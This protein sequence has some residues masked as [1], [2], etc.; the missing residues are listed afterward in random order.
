M[1]ILVGL[2]GQAVGV[3]SFPFMAR[4]AVE[5]RIREMS[6]L[7]NSTLRYIALVIP[8]SALLIVLRQEVIV[9][10]FQRGR[11]DAAATALTAQVLIFFLA[12]AFAFAA[13]TVVVRGYYAMQNTLF[14]AVFG[15]TAVVLSIPFYIG[16]MHLFGVSGVAL[17]VSLSAIFQVVL[18][19]AL[20]NRRCRNPASRGVYSVYARVT[21]LSVVLGAVLELLK[22][23]LLEDVAV[24]ALFGNL[25]V[26]ALIGIVF[27]AMLLAGGT[28]LRIREISTII[29]RATGREKKKTD[30][31]HRRSQR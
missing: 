27:S 18:L 3:A 14:P 17:A 23:R 20:W 7:L 13:Q 4:L 24:S 19:Y 31:E 28:M 6:D 22:T 2:F 12:G 29:A 1:L 15:S 11:F 21:G 5:N 10:L 8:F 25:M 16:G 9:I 26:C 30:R